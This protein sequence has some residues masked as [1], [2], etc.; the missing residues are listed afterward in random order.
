MVFVDADKA[1]YRNYV[2]FLL[3]SKLIDVGGFFVLDNTLLQ[4][5]TYSDVKNRSVSGEAIAKFN[6][7]LSAEKRVEQVILPLRDGVT[8]ARRIY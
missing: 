4:G 7:Y 8:I 2:K 6:E 1:S 3:D 5:E